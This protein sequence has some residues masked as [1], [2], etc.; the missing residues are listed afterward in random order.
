M[1]TQNQQADWDNAHLAACHWYIEMLENETPHFEEA[2]W[3]SVEPEFAVLPVRQ[4]S[5]APAGDPPFG[6]GAKLKAKPGA[7]VGGTSRPQ[8]ATKSGKQQASVDIS[9]PSKHGKQTLEN[10]SQH[11]HPEITPSQSKARS[12][13]PQLSQTTRS[14]ADGSE[15]S[16]WSA[17]VT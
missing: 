4:P 3:R 2:N 10:V 7:R 5:K 8:T 13:G 16:I 6:Q 11:V 14:Y 12:F 1:F 17:V 9:K 15:W